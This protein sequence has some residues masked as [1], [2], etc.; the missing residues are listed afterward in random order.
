M[1][2]YAKYSENNNK[3]ISFKAIDKKLLK[4]ILKF[5]KELVI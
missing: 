2:E 4:S 5:G 3:T 1:T